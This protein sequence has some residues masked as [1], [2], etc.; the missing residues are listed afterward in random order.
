MKNGGENCFQEEAVFQ[1]L[2]IIFGCAK[3]RYVAA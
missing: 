2:R 3:E 1:Y